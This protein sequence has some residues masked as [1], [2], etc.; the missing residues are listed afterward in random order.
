MQESKRSESVEWQDDQK[1]LKERQS[2]ATSKETLSDVEDS[3]KVPAANP[4]R[5]ADESRLPSP[6]GSSDEGRQ[7]NDGSGPM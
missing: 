3:E 1:E 4:T 7:G 5:A 6:D 2:E